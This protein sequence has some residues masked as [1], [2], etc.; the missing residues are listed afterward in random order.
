MVLFLTNRYW[1]E[2]F[3]NI[4]CTKKWIKTIIESIYED[5]DNQIASILVFYIQRNYLIKRLLN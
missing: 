3:Y 2:C 5:V 4:I 1:R